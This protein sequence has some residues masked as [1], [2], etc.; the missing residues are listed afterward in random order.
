MT[1]QRQRRYLAFLIVLLVVNVKAQVKQSDLPPELRA[2]DTRISGLLDDIATAFRGG[3]SEMALKDIEEALR[4]CAAHKL[5]RDCALVQGASAVARI[6]AADFEGARLQFE[7]GME[8]AIDL[9]DLALQAEF[10]DGIGTLTSVAGDPK[11]AIEV[12]TTALDTAKRAKS[13][14]IQSQIHGDLARQEFLLGSMSEAEKNLDEAL[15]IDELNHYGLERLHR[16]YKGYALL[17]KSDQNVAP[18]TK[19]FAQ[20]RD[21]AHSAE[22]WYAETLATQAIAMIDA[23]TGK[24]QDALTELERVSKRNGSILTKLLDIENIAGVFEMAGKHEEAL[25]KWT[26]LHELG[27]SLKND[28]M[29]LEANTRAASLLI[30]LHRP[31]EAVAK[32]KENL[33]IAVRRNSNIAIVQSLSSLTTLIQTH[34]E[35]S[36]IAPFYEQMLEA[37][38]EHSSDG[39]E[40]TML[41]FSTLVQL[42]NEYKRLKQFDKAAAAFRAAELLDPDS[43][44]KLGNNPKHKAKLIELLHIQHAL[45]LDALHDNLGAL[46]QAYRAF[47]SATK[48]EDK[49]LYE[50]IVTD[51]NKWLN[52]EEPYARLQSLL[53]THRPW[54]AL[55][56]AECLLLEESW[57][58]TW[59]QEHAE[60]AKQTFLAIISA[61]DQM[62]EVKDGPALLEG[63]LNDIP[64]EFTVLR[65]AIARQIAA[66][67]LFRDN[68]PREAQQFL[69]IVLKANWSGSERFIFE[70]QCWMAV[71]KSS[72]GEGESAIEWAN[73]CGISAKAL[74]A[75]AQRYAQTVETFASL[76]TL[77]VPSPEA[78]DAVIKQFGDTPELRER[79]A[80][81]YAIH[82]DGAYAIKN[83]NRAVELLEAA[84]RLSEGGNEALYC[85][86]Q[87]R[88]LK[89]SEE[90][91]H[92]IE[93]ARKLFVKS[94]DKDGLAKTDLE[95]SRLLESQG[96]I[97]RAIVAAQRASDHLGREPTSTNV[98]A[99]LWLAQLTGRTQPAKAVPLLKRAADESA[100]TKD[101]SLEVEALLAFADTLEQQ[102]SLGEVSSTLKKAAGIAETNSGTLDPYLVAA[103]TG[104]FYERTGD[105]QAAFASYLTAEQAASQFPVQQGFALNNQAA[106]LEIL[107]DWQGAASAANR[108]IE[109]FKLQNYSPGVVSSLGELI[110]VYVDR[111]S[112]LVDLQ[113]AET[114]Y[115]N[116]LSIDPKAASSLLADMIELYLQKHEYQR[117]LAEAGQEIN[118]C[119]N[120]S[121]CKANLRIS[122]AEAYVGLGNPD[123]ATES[124]RE[125]EKPVQ[126]E[127]D[128]Y[129]QARLKYVAGK[130]FFAKGEFSHA[131]EQLQAV[132]DLIARVGDASVD[133]GKGIRSNYSYI[134]DDLLSSL[135][136]EFS[137]G[138]KTA[139]WKALDYADVEAAGS[140]DLRWRKI[141]IKRL[142]EQLP[143]SMRDRDREITTRIADLKQKISSAA[144]GSR[145][146]LDLQA[147]LSAVEHDKNEFITEM[148]KVAPKYA[149][150]AYPTSLS[151][152][153]LSLQPGEALLR[154]HVAPD[155]IYEWITGGDAPGELKFYSVKADRQELRRVVQEIKAAFDQGR[156]DLLR[157][158]SVNSI[159]TLIL[160]DDISSVVRR[161]KHL[162]YVPDDCLFLVPLEMLLTDGSG[163]PDTSISYYPSVRDYVSS[164][165]ATVKQF[166]WTRAFMGYGDPI[167]SDDDPRLYALK[168]VRSSQLDV[169]SQ[170]P[171]IARRG[172]SLDRIPATG[173]ELNAIAKLFDV[174]QQ[175]NE[176]HVGSEATKDRVLHTDLTSYRYIHFAT[177]GLLPGDARID[178]PALVLS[179]GPHTDDILLSMSDVLGLKLNA[180]LVV[181]SACNTGSGKLAKGEGVMNLGKAFMS[182]GASSVTMSLW[183]V[184]DVS[185]SLLMQAFYRHLLAGT[186]KHLALTRAR[187]EVYAAGYTNP[188]FW[189]PFIL[190]G[191]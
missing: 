119:G 92:Y 32:Y 138:N 136:A 125:A 36:S 165:N 98:R 66:L 186:P 81:A 20:V 121:I 17:A 87:A 118:E 130:A 148:R 63:N 157:T 161:A 16:V 172:I 12:W 181:L 83:A 38:R 97:Q 21:A 55:E 100:Q 64:P 60:K 52:V 48:A 176:I 62:R 82:N 10:L 110:S 115:Q 45:V 156:P 158:N 159:S 149:A 113:K 80:Q 99:A 61:L 114:L 5:R 31:E 28:L 53:T 72:A 101:K 6:S 65:A 15:Q 147:T 107:G 19:L 120:D 155:R 123:S 142:A 143:L 3:N 41:K 188:F 90:A 1:M 163:V 89:E 59:R 105:M 133:S 56:L 39:A 69:S 88:V 30:T 84:G 50:P 154:I 112:D 67:Q 102:N 189:A 164:R 126:K 26:E 44:D 187:K 27:I 76:A 139:A 33:E 96:D 166:A 178:E 23:R 175:P 108:A 106:I 2:E 34:P 91:K 153:E 127:G 77:A 144:S 185:T 51:I 42:G 132:C 162:I 141:F 95:E 169:L 70:A 71:A 7:Q 182:A 75:Q 134:F 177:H 74:D 152:H 104:S 78:V 129:L 68:K 18:A 22:D 8:I 9:G 116:A 140:F 25:Q 191:E 94:S 86:F 46:Q 160:P 11:R 13:L 24:L 103:A 180:D 35:L 47:D 184:S 93:V 167:T 179:R 29:L 109:R 150:L 131:T 135:Q 145:S 190:V 73:K 37:I 122:M 146:V 111:G 171:V 168:E 49:E 128:A 173:E 174:A 151:E 124:L 4:E 43:L 54:E 170:D 137:S 58:S 183:Q 40:G 57:N 85:S 117:V 14:Y 79:L